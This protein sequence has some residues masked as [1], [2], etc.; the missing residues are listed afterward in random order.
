[1]VLETLASGA[2]WVAF[3]GGSNQLQ[4][5]GKGTTHTHA[6]Q[7]SFVFERRGVRWATVLGNVP[8][9]GYATKG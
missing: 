7:G 9:Q 4:Q 8:P 2:S 1:M 6:D 5:L 3:K